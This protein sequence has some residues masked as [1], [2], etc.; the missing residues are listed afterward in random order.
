MKYIKIIQSFKTFIALLAVVSIIAAASLYTMKLNLGSE[1]RDAWVVKIEV[2][3][4][5]DSSEVN[6]IVS[7]N[8][9]SPSKVDWDSSNTFYIYFQE[10]SGD[11][12]SK[13]EETIADNISGVNSVST[14]YHTPEKIFSIQSRAT[15]LLSITGAA[16]A[17]YV[18]FTLKGKGLNYLQTLSI[19]LADIFIVAWA[20]VVTIAF[21]ALLG[22][23]GLYMDKWFVAAM[24]MVMDVLLINMIFDDL[25]FIDFSKTHTINTLSEI[26]DKM[27]EQDWPT[28]VLV[29][30][31]STFILIFPF[32]LFGMPLMWVSAIMI[33]VILISLF[34]VYALKMY[35]LRAIELVL[36]KSDKVSKLLDKQW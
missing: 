21:S 34:S 13:V 19:V 8:Y 5:I 36:A 16:F 32:L 26:W 27:I 20:T 17:L 12:L 3:H 24:L 31:V 6:K 4:D 30:V 28:N 29:A 22:G 35:T 33:L 14:Y 7:N 11:D 18:I 10:I 9:Q 25:R 1:Y 23:A 2:D 15:N